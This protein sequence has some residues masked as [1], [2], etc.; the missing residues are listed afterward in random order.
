MVDIN[1]DKEWKEYKDFM[2]K[3]FDK[4][5]EYVKIKRTGREKIKYTAVVLETGL[6]IIYRIPS[7]EVIVWGVGKRYS[8]GYIAYE[9]L[10]RKVELFKN[11][12]KEVTCE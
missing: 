6:N 9:Q 7:K 10:V 4:I 3:E 11:L 5:G 12:M 8:D 1:K 2:E